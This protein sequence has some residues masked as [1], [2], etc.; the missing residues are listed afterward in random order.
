MR[1]E[2]GTDDTIQYEDLRAS[3]EGAPRQEITEHLINV[4]NHLQVIK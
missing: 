1:V 2:R 4:L 3:P